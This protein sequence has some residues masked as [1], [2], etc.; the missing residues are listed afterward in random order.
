MSETAGRYVTEKLG[1][2]VRI[3]ELHDSGFD[4]ESFDVITLHHLIDRCHGDDRPD[5]PIIES[6]AGR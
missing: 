3:G 1:I 2:N 6:L 4:N 5:C